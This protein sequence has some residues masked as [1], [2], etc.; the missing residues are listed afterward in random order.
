L[1]KCAAP[2]CDVEFEATTHNKKYHSPQCKRDAENVARRRQVQEIQAAVLSAYDPPSEESDQLRVLKD[3]HSKALK[4]LEKLKSSKA[5]LATAV[6]EAAKDG[7]AA[8]DFPPIA[9]PKKDERVKD[10]EIAVAVLADW[11]LAKVTPSYSS[12]I[13]EKRIEEYAEKVIRLT[14]IQRADHPVRKLH[15]WAL[16]D[17]VEGELIFPGQSHLVDS[18]LYRQVTI[19]GPRI[20]GNFLR[21][22]LQEFESVHFCGVIGNHGAL[23]GRARRDYDPETNAD[24]MLYRIIQQIFSHEDRLTFDI[25]DGPAERNWY[26]IDKI[27]DYK[28][29][30]FHGDQIRSFGSQ[31]GFMK[32]VLGWK[33]G[34]IEDDFDDAYMGHYHQPTLMT[35]NTVTL[36]VSGSPESYNT[37]AIE[38]LAAVGFPSQ[39]LHF[40]HP[41]NGITGSY[42][43][44]LK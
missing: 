22:M 34:A 39:P 19:D 40:V 17:I 13:C 41:E 28:T 26:T 23:G 21:R 29:L 36:R 15:I 2:D 25:P 38:S 3:A 4:E 27:G 14:N 43:V 35:L 33:S 8:L 18:S 37:Y 20:L 11:Q 5:D 1:K 24:R 12:E 16:G 10:E 9:P 6:F 32:K 7:I 44:W 42:T 31:Y 30:L